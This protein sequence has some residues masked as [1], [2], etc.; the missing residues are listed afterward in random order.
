MYPTWDKYY[1]KEVHWGQPIP[2][3]E[4]HERLERLKSNNVSVKV[5]GT[6]VYPGT[7]IARACVITDI[8]DAIHIQPGKQVYNV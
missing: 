6:P 3:D 7:V 4:E 2:E 1:F 8:K 5:Q